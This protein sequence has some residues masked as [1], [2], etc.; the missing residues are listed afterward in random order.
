M[1]TTTISQDVKQK[2][3]IQE[4]EEYFLLVRVRQSLTEA[5]SSRVWLIP[6]GMRV[7]G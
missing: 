4:A 2:D 6:A 7:N 3:W 5:K 1:N